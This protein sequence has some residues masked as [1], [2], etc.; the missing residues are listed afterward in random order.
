MFPSLIALVGL[1][2]QNKALSPFETCSFFA[3][4]AVIA[5][6]IA[7]PISAAL[8]CLKIRLAKESSPPIYYRI[9][10]CVFYFSSLLAP[11]SFV[12]VLF[13]PRRFDMIGYLIVFTLFIA[14]VACSFS[15]YICK[16][17]ASNLEAHI[18]NETR[19]DSASTITHM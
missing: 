11:L 16:K 3:N 15:D 18:T 4:M 13:L 8:F 2:F 6:I 14:V 19:S 10:H 5:Y 1:K 17:S 9:L 12:L 7:I